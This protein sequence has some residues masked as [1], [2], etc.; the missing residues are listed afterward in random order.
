MKF[1]FRSLTIALCLLIIPI[2]AVVTAAIKQRFED[3]P[4]RVFAG[5][6]LISGPIYK[7]VEPDWEFVNTIDTV[8]LQL[9]DP[10]LSRR[11]WIASAQG[12]L[13]IWSGYMNSLVG[14]LWKTWPAQA[15]ADGRALLRIDGIRYERNLLR[16]IND[17]VF[18]ELSTVVSEKYPSHFTRDSVERGEVWVFEAKPKT[19]LNHQIVRVLN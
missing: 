13:F 12:R 17:P 9:V 19:P 10:P 15:N 8:E 16:L 11:I 5:G 1:M 7:G 2:S 14:Q 6:P 4:N 3:G 18:E